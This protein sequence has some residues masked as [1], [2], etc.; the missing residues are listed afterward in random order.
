[1]DVE[2]SFSR[3]KTPEDEEFVNEIKFYTGIKSKEQQTYE[4]Y[5]KILRSCD[6]A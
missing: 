3:E 2:M 5:R 1:M 4:D 6:P